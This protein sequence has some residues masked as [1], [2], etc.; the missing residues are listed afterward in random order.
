MKKYTT[1]IYDRS[2]VDKAILA[3]IIGLF[4]IKEKQLRFLEFIESPR[5]YEDFLDEILND[6]RNLKPECIVELAG[7]EQTVEVIAQKLRKFGAVEKSYLLSKDDETDGK[8]GNLKKILSLVY[9]E[10]LVY[11]IGSKLGYYE[12]HENWRYILRAI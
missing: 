8:I 5:R 10:G 12:G 1:E 4:V 3:E 7:N 2:R 9:V 6:P 11:C